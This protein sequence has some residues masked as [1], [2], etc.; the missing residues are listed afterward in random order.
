M[1]RR[2]N[3]T[4]L[5]AVIVAAGA[6]GGIALRPAGA[7]PP[8]GSTTTPISGPVILDEIG[9]KSIADGHHVKLSTKGLSDVYVSHIKIT[10]GGNS[11]W[12]SHPGP[13]IISVKAGTLTLYD[14]CDDFLTPHVYPAG[15]GLVED[16][17]CVHMVVNHGNTDL[18]IVVMQIVPLGAPRRIEEPA[19]N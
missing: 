12:H 6:F 1:L 11:G 8:Q 3:K 2:M 9:T 5:L 15:T 4:T 19:P 17:K 13:S 7:T 16:A 10:S 14:D 18:E